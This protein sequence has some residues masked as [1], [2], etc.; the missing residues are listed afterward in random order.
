MS[1][2]LPTI[3]YTAPK[4]YASSGSTLFWSVVTNKSL[5]RSLIACMHIHPS[6]S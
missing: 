6:N 1:L 5:V 2:G 3:P 4:C